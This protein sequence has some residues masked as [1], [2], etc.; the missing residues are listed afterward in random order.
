[1]RPGVLRH[2]V[3]KHKILRRLASLFPS[4]RGGHTSAGIIEPPL[5]SPFEDRVGGRHRDRRCLSRFGT[6]SPL[7]CL[8]DVGDGITHAA[9]LLIHL[10]HLHRLNIGTGRRGIELRQ[11]RVRFGHRL[12]AA[13]PE[14]KCVAQ[15]YAARVVNEVLLDHVVSP[16]SGCA[17]GICRLRFENVRFALK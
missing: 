8:R 4:G 17:C 7:Q 5:G 2:W 12:C 10:R 3:G 9:G 6:E 15:S 14:R 16:S 13:L 11:H 1:M